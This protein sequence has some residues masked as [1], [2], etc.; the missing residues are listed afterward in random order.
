[1][2]RKRTTRQIIIDRCNSNLADQQRIT[3]R[4]E[5]ILGTYF[6][7]CPEHSMKISQVLEQS[8]LL[9]GVLYHTILYVKGA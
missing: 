6:E 5:A 1:M 4:L 8:Q 3:A 9:E 2:A 7:D